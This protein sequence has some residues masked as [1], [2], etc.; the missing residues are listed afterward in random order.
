[1]K[2]GEGEEVGCCEDCDDGEEG[3]DGCCVDMVHDGTS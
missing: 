3:D 1:M 2:E